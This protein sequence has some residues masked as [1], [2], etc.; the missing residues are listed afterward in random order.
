MTMY[1]MLLWW[2][3]DQ[4]QDNIHTYHAP[5]LLPVFIKEQSFLKTCQSLTSSR[6]FMP[7][8]KSRLLLPSSYK[9][10]NG[11][12]PLSHYTSWQTLAFRCFRKTAR[13][14]Y[15]FRHVCP[16]TNSAVR[17]ER[18]GYRWMDFYEISYLR[19]YLTNLSRNVQISLQSDKKNE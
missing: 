11:Q 10:A 9:T 16:S 12:Y 4:L 15:S 5:P 14:D 18:V 1:W 2:Q 8:M 17:K 13:S 19:I 7:F 6:N 3:D